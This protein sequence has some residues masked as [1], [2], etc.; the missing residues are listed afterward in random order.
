M[1]VSLVS[2]GVGDGLPPGDRRRGLTVYLRLL[3]SGNGKPSST[4]QHHNNLFPPKLT[5]F[6]VSI[7]FSLPVLNGAL[8]LSFH[9]LVKIH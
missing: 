9:L 6:Y 5:L 2:Y 7:F 4:D 3:I 1:N 8:P